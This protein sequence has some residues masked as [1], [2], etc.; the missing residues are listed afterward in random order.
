[1]LIRA[2]TAADDD[3]CVAIMRRTHELDG[4]PRYWPAKPDRFLRA[5]QETD[6]WVAVLDDDAGDQPADATRVVGQVA[7]HSADGE[8]VVAL[9]VPASGQPVDRLAVLAR[10][11]VDPDVRGRGVARSLVRTA[12]LR[13]HETGRRPVLD[14]LRSTP[15]P[16]ALYESEGWDRLG[17]TTLDLAGLGYGSVP[18]LELWVYLGPAPA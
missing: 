13:A 15:G 7:L 10:L 9:A 2:K 18:P 5:R 8:P 6:A 14:V 17:P 11:L 12:V 3:A 1:M 4:Y 16:I